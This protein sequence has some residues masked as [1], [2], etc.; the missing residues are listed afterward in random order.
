MRLIHCADIHLES[1]LSTN[2]DDYK[3]KTRRQELLKSFE[4]MVQYAANNDVNCVLIAG[5]LFDTDSVSKTAGNAVYSLVLSNPDISFYYLKGNHD[6]NSFFTGLDEVPDNLHMFNESLTTYKLTEGITLSG[7]EFSHSNCGE[8]YDVMNLNAADFNIVTLHGQIYESKAGDKAETINLAMLRNKSIDYLALGHIHKYAL[9]KL[10]ARGT[11][12]YPGCIEGRG[13]DECGTHGFIVLDIDEMTHEFK[14]EFVPWG[15]RQIYTL[16]TDISG[17]LDSVG[18]L[19]MVKNDLESNHVMKD[20]MV[21]VVLSGEIDAEAEINPDYIYN[22][23]CDEYYFVKIYNETKVKM[24]FERYSLDV[25][26]KGEFIRCVMA[27]SKLS[28][29]TKGEIIRT[30][31]LALAGEEF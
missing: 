8:I 25:S 7:I 24:D 30:G 23:I 14:A 11:Y 3:R 5:D 12:C 27:D 18:A 16:E 10:D 29:S 19:N 1:K 21:K 26:L 4:D 15:K 22:S 28:E 17:C 2:L 20:D 6:A 31:L 13:F 9:D